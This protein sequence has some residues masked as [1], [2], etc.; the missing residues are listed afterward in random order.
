[1]NGTEKL[2]IRIPSLQRD[3]SDFFRELAGDERLINLFV[4]DPMGV[5]RERFSF[6]KSTTAEDSGDASLNRLLFSVLSN[7]EFAAWLSEYQANLTKQ[8]D[9]ALAAP[10]G[11]QV[12]EVID[13]TKIMQD[14]A[15]AMMRVGDREIIMSLMAGPQVALRQS[16]FVVWAAIAAVAVAVVVFIVFAGAAPTL[17][18]AD[19]QTRASIAQSLRAVGE[20]LVSHAAEIR[21]AGGLTNS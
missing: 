17:G 19:D 1:M 4:A 8:I 5:L 18:N 13:Q 21:A 7:R 6:I 12:P 3:T 10:A 16:P 14:L 20:R 11:Q 9:W 15:D 2:L